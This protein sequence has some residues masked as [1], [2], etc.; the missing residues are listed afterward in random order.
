MVR[1][2]IY[3]ACPKLAITEWR[4]NSPY[5]DAYRCIAW[6]ACHTDRHMWPNQDYWWFAGFPLI[7]IPE[8]TPLS[9]FV[10]G[11]GAL[12]YKPCE[13]RTFEFGYQKVA[14]YA[15]DLGI[16]HMARQHFL[17]RGWLS[18]L[19]DWEDIVHRELEDISGD[20]SPMA[21]QYGQVVQV[22]KRNWW[23][24]AVNLCLF[25]SVWHASRYWFH[26]VTHPSW[27]RIGRTVS[28]ENVQGK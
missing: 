7:E 10:Q 27:G 4:I 5:D 21:Y 28:S 15:N 9:Y 18:K 19:G 8:E 17:G 25:R 26:R 16:T 6:A 1:Q 3:K 11:F 20:M 24:A 14:I 22:M 2:D 23:Y 13:N 12:G